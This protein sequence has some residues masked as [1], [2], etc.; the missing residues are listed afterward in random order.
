MLCTLSNSTKWQKTYLISSFVF[1]W[2]MWSTYCYLQY[3]VA[4]NICEW[5]IPYSEMK[6]HWKCDY[7]EV[8]SSL[9]L[10]PSTCQISATANWA[11]PALTGKIQTCINTQKDTFHLHVLELIWQ[12]S[13]GFLLRFQEM[14]FKRTGF[15]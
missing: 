9:S 2:T 10:A 4:L 5:K 8:L 13:D 11:I 7:R 1:L 12:T 6:T 3:Y 14:W 15:A